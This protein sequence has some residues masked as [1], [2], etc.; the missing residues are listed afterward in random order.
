MTRLIHKVSGSRPVRIIA[1]TFL[2]RYAMMRVG[3]LD[4]LDPVSAQERTLRRLV[5]KARNTR[6]GMDHDFDGIRTVGDYQKRVPLRTFEQMWHDYWQPVFPRIQGVA[7][8]E[9]TPY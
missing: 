9:F 4:R 7:W 2:N 6:F 3:E 5:R 1:D 8:P